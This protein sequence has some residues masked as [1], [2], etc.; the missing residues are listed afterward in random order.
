MTTLRRNALL[1]RLDD[2][3]IG[4]IANGLNSSDLCDFVGQ[5]GFD[6]ALI[7]FEHGSVSW[8]NMA[9]ITRACELWDMVP[10]VRPN[11]LAVSLV[12]RALD[13][14]AA[15]IMVPHVIT[16]ADAESAAAACRYP[17]VGTRGVARNRRQYGVSDYFERVN[18]EVVCLALIEDVAAA[19]NIDILL[20]VDGIDVYYVA[21]SDM[22]ASMGH[23][24]EPEHP[25]V[26]RV[27]D[28]SIAAVVAAGKVAGTLVTDSNVEDY[29]A[30]GV[31]CVG[32]SWLQW[33]ADG[34][35][36]FLSGIRTRE[37]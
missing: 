18:N 12:T 16:R 21:P 27:I 15:G 30:K 6:A 24:G 33:V 10:I 19:R 3:E 25:D 23:L 13:Q 35:S 14:G 2:G 29:L 17:P 28:E 32:V 11:R 31:R 22:A 7:D 4:V 34:A 37:R 8:N 5:F 36:Q 26:V 9:D 20:A 1:R